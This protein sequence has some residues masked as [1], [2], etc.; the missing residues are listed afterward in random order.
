IILALLGA[1]VLYK[2]RWTQI[3]CALFFLWIMIGS[4]LPWSP[5]EMLHQLPG[6]A[7]L[8]VPSRF[9]LFV[10]LLL[11]LLAG[12][13][14]DFLKTRLDKSRAL[15][16]IPLALIA[17]VALDLVWVNG[18]VFKAAFS[19]PPIEVA[20]KGPFRQYLKSPYMKTYQDRILYPAWPNW[21]SAAFPAVLEN[22]GVIDSYRT[23]P[24]ESFTVPFGYPG[25]QGE[26][27]FEEEQGRIENL[28]ITPN[29][30][31]VKTN[32]R[33]RVLLINQNFD[34]GWKVWAAPSTPVMNLQGL[35][36]VRLAPGQTEISL[37][38]RPKAFY[39]GAGISLGFLVLF[40]FLY[41]RAGQKDRSLPIRP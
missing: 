6:L 16:W 40:L 24:F 3:V 2:K 9:N 33:G 20:A 41:F 11:A 30:I 31:D 8:R 38:Y 5:W 22:R 32:G 13:G 34:E 36:G 28:E 19:I 39:I 23:I 1:I 26:A 7:M 10:I 12:G 17:L 15:S 4:V 14:L 21:H 18:K 27:W 35:L 29:R 25:Y 37:I